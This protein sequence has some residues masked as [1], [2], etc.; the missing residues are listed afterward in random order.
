MNNLNTLNGL[1]RLNELNY[2][3]QLNIEHPKK[4]RPATRPPLCENVKKCLP[5][6]AL[7]FAYHL[8]PQDKEDQR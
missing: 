5:D 2:L 1:N 6:R 7:F 8:A 3:E 4:K